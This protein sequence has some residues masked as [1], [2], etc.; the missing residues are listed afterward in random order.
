MKNFGLSIVCETLFCEL[1][2]QYPAEDRAT[3]R[4]DPSADWGQSRSGV[5]SVLSDTRHLSFLPLMASI[6]GN[7]LNLRSMDAAIFLSRMRSSIAMTRTLRCSHSSIRA[8]SPS[9]DSKRREAAPP[10]YEQASC[11]T[12]QWHNEL[13]SLPRAKLHPTLSSSNLP[14]Q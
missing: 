7:A 11:D 14:T 1:R 5:A 10:G 9:W 4:C 13:T 3:Q 12:A 8:F 2:F 6:L